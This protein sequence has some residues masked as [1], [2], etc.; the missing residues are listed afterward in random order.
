M[1]SMQQLYLLPSF[2]RG[3][4][5]GASYFSPTPAR[6]LPKRPCQNPEGSGGPW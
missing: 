5:G 6:L 2:G 4:G 3:K 1:D